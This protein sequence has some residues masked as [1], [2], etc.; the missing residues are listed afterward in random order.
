MRLLIKLLPRSALQGFSSFP[1]RLTKLDELYKLR[2]EK[3]I[4]LVGREYRLAII[5]R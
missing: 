1:V 2:P 3:Y 4:L 5:V